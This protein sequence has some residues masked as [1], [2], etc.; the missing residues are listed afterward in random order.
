MRQK[1]ETGCDNSALNKNFIRLSPTISRHGSDES[2]EPSAIEPSL[3]GSPSVESPRTPSPLKK[4]VA[5]D[6]ETDKYSFFRN[7][8]DKRDQKDPSPVK[9]RNVRKKSTKS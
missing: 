8:T 2:L 7:M 9:S 6:E 4:Q 3:P 5:G 1:S